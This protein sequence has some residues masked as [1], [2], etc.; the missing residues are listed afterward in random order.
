M[1]KIVAF[2]PSIDE[3]CSRLVLGSMP[4]EVS[5]GAQQYYAH[6]RNSFWPIVYQVLSEGRQVPPA[7]Y[8][9]R[10]RFLMGHGIALWDVL[11]VCEREGS[12]D[13]AIREPEAND[14]EALFQRYP[15]IG[16][17]YCNGGKAYELFTKQVMPTLTVSR[18]PRCV[19]LPSTSPAHAIPFE[20]KAE[21][22]LVLRAS[23]KESSD[24]S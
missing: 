1:A 16:T 7:A 10:L 20:R 21:A 12:L 3:G 2:P 8:E 13:T 11:R 5:L 19:K 4:G 22:W 17:V 24:S 18:T 15:V 6:P 14:F 9:E 23:G